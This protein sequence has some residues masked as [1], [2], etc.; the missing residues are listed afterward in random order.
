MKTIYPAI[1]LALLTA[2]CSQDEAS[3]LEPNASAN[4]GQSADTT[5]ASQPLPVWFLGTVHHVPDNGGVWVVRTAGGTQYQPIG[6]PE[7]FQ[8]EGLAVEVE[9]RKHGK[10]VTNETL[11]GT[12]DIVQIRKRGG[13]SG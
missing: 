8:V 2:A 3:Q 9:A 4:S 7:E 11:G 1:A 5:A 13:N 6:L 12:I 10:A